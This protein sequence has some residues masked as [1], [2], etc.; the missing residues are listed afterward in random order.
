MIDEVPAQIAFAGDQVT[1]VL[2][3]ID[4]INVNL[5]EWNLKEAWFI[6]GPH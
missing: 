1:M 5:G 4:I 2:T 3:G 6:I